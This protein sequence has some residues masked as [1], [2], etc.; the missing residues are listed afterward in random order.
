[1]DGTVIIWA[2]ERAHRF[3]GTASEKTALVSV[4]RGERRRRVLT[5]GRT[6]LQLLALQYELEEPLN[7]N[8][9]TF[10]DIVE[11]AIER[12]HLESDEAPNV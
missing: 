11:G 6:M 12:V 1:M 8:G 3:D 5:V 4:P 7:L 10:E 2:G 9:D